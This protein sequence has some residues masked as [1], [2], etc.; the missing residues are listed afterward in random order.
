[1]SHRISSVPDEIDR[2]R[3]LETLLA[4]QPHVLKAIH[5]IPEEYQVKTEA[6]LEKLIRKRDP[7]KKFPIT[8][9]H[10]KIRFWDCYRREL[11]KENQGHMLIS[12][13]TGGVCTGYYWAGILRDKLA[14]A[15]LVHPPV[16]EYVVMK[17]IMNLAFRKMRQAMEHPLVN[18]KGNLNVPLLKEIHQIFKTV[19]DR[20]DGAVVQR[21]QILQKT[22]HVP[23]P[24]A[25][26]Q[27]TV[28]QLDA[29]MQRVEQ[30]LSQAENPKT[31]QLT[32][33]ALYE[34][35]AMADLPTHAP[36]GEGYIPDDELEADASAPTEKVEDLFGDEIEQ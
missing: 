16:D 33:P 19:K 21:H 18:S 4:R 7:D 35:P 22:M 13:I 8:L 27:D 14:L 26:S 3:T 10:L 24:G 1:M 30:Q 5:E 17:D 9:A 23:T 6:E 15:W 34:S 2:P 32:I 31:Q 12:D 36:P 28:E 29:L 25:I 11:H 20:M